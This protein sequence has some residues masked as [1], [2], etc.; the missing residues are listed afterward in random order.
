MLPSFTDILNISRTGM[1]AR[2]KD[3]DI[4]SNN[5]ANV[6]TTAYKQVRGNFQE[7]LEDKTQHVKGTILSNTQRDMTQGIVEESYSPYHLA[8]K[9]E[10]FFTLTLPDNSKA[11]TRDGLFQ[12]D[13]QRKIVNANGYYLAWNGTIPDKA[14]AVQIN[15]QGKVSVMVNNIWQDLGHIQLTR[16]TNPLGLISIGDNAFT[17]S[18]A[19]G[20]PQTNNAGTNELGNILSKMKES[21]NVSWGEQATQMMITQRGFQLSSRSFQQADAM[22]ALAI[23]LRR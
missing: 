18:E 11:Y 6:N 3:M 1:Q 23:S 12:L 8:I 17:E 5:I 7:L 2:T 20:A 16:F 21:S 9:G 22:Q 14:E 13:A 4:I 19:S 10:G 15:E